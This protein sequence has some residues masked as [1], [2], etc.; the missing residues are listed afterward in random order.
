[1][2]LFYHRRLCL[3]NFTGYWPL[4]TVL[5]ALTTTRHTP[6]PPDSLATVLP[7]SASPAG[8]G[9][10]QTLPHWLLPST[11][12][13]I[14]NDRTGPDLDY[15]PLSSSM[16][17]NRAIP[18]DKLNFFSP[19]A[20]AQPLTVL[21]WLRAL[22][23]SGTRHACRMASGWNACSAAHNAVGLAGESPVV[24]IDCLPT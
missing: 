4:A 8:S 6:L 22:N 2:A 24:G 17:P 7:P 20:A 3:L 16:S 9:R 10:A 21:S 15:R 23:A 18:W 11:D 13:R 1:L 14:G 19:H 5:V 12:R